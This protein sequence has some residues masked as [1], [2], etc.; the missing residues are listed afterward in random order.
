VCVVAELLTAGFAAT[1]AAVSGGAGVTYMCQSPSKINMEAGGRGSQ[2]SAGACLLVNIIVM[3]VGQSITA[4]MPSFVVAGLL[5]YAG[6]AYAAEGVYDSRSQLDRYEYVV[7]VSI[8]LLSLLW[9]LFQAVGIGLGLLALMF[10]VRYAR[11]TQFAAV[12]YRGSVAV[13]R[14]EGFLFFGSIASMSEAVRD[15]LFKVRHTVRCIAVHC[16]AGPI[17]F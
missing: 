13:V 6:M 17:R 12:E 11:E 4:F 1:A 16:V 15:V 9:G 7:V 5:F 2:W 3:I 14:C 8:A 10:L